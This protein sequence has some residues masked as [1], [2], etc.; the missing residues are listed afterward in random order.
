MASL[1]RSIE[2]KDTRLPVQVRETTSEDD[3]VFFLRKFTTEIREWW[4]VRRI[5]ITFDLGESIP[6]YPKGK[7]V[8]YSLYGNPVYTAEIEINYVSNKGRERAP[9]FNFLTKKESIAV[10]EGETLERNLSN[11]INEY[12]NHDSWLVRAWRA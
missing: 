4:G 12:F 7:N 9:H 11:Y 1:V 6:S 3:R 8:D 5:D 10:K 2:R